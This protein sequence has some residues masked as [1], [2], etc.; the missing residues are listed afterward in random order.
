MRRICL[1]MALLFCSLAQAQTRDKLLTIE[2]DTETND[3]LRGQSVTLMQTDYQV[4]YGT[5]LLDK[6][7]HLQVRV[8]AG[9]HSLRIQR[10]GYETVDTTFAVQ[11]DMTVNVMLREKTRTPFALT[12]TLGHDAYTGEDNAL[13]VWNTEAPVFFDDFESYEPF[14]VQFGQWTGIDADREAAAPIIGE[15]PN[16]GTLQY[17]QIINPLEVNPTWWYDYPILRP[18]SGK[19]YVGFTRTMTGNANDDWLIS[20]VVIPGTDHWVS[21]MAKA[22]DRYDERFQVYVTTKT[23][24]PVQA[25]FV[26]L[27]QDNYE[28]ADY[29]GW[30]E[31]AYSLADY[32]GKP[33]RIAI[34]YISH[35]SMYGSFMLMLDDFY[36]GQYNALAARARSHRAPR[37]SPDN[38]NELFHLFLDG[39]QVDETDTYRYVFNNLSAGEHTLGVRAV[40][41][42][43]QSDMVTTTVNVPADGYAHVTFNV[44]AQS[45]QTADGEVINL[46]NTNT[47]ESYYLTVSEGKA[48]ILS[49]PLGTYVVNIGEGA[50][51]E[52]QQTL[53]VK[54]DATLNITLT[55]R[56]IAPYNITADVTGNTNGTIDVQLRW[57]QELTFTDSFEDYDDFATGEFGGWK[58]YDLDQM[59][60]YPISLGGIIVTFPGSGTQSKPQPLA[61]MVFNPWN[62]MPP[63]LPTD[64][65]VMAPTGDK[66]IVFFS[67][68]QATADKWLVSPQYTIRDGFVLN[69]TAKG[70]SASYPESLEFCVSTTGDQPSDFTVLSTVDMLTSEEWTI[71]QTDLSAFAGQTVRLAVHYTSRDAFFTQIDDFTVGPLDGD[72]KS[73]DFGNVVKYEIYLDGVL[74]GESETSEFLLRGIS[75]GSHTVG[76]RA[77]YQN[78][79]SQIATYQITST[80]IESIQGPKFKTDDNTYSYGLNGIR[81]FKPTTR[82][83]NVVKGEDRSYKILK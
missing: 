59:P 38:P 69:V 67:P 5:L 26:R 55:D 40:Y 74:F 11:E 19:Q 83:V 58:S 44:T 63:M 27:D 77:I 31:F 57:N 37:R 29:T 61:P 22:A 17:A 50:F 68:Q 30:H 78:N 6:D 23:D 81:L 1:L 79:A 54:A 49:L 15:Y 70:Y 20:P 52:Y 73:I 51:E 72:G 10:G 53:Q 75:N 39:K 12:A 36:V 33:V 65:A 34:R 48:D 24:N 4:S 8:Y 18:F 46:V 64:V 71:Y 35:Y 32:A 28:T 16:R 42:A 47:S 3:L 82:Q 7:G 25:D 76:I 13:L 62:T 80:G 21:F 41:L 9:N 60:V 2:V 66:T 14:A 56:V 43:A 45:K